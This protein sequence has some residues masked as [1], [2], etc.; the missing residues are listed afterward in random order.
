MSEASFD[1]VLR[2]PRLHDAA[3]KLAGE[4]VLSREPG[5]LM[6]YW[7][8]KAGVQQIRLAK[9]MGL[10]PSV[11]SDYEGGRRKSPGS[12]FIR[13]YVA[14]LV[15]MDRERGVLL[16]S[17][18]ADDNPDAILSIGEFREPISVSG[19][20]EALSLEILTGEDQLDRSLYGYTV[21]DSIRAIYALSGVEFYRIFGS[22]TERILVFTKV[23]MGRS[24]LVAV[25]VSQL[26]PRMVVVHGPERV[27]PLSVELARRE[28]IVMAVARI[29]VRELVGKLSS[30]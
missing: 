21:L 12:Q 18:P 13:K 24:P 10:S 22:T 20:A 16:G 23:G 28:R 19:I 25:R 9:E 4:L 8:E 1:D 2:D 17:K 27:D 14:S 7:R 6:K 15:K 5:R 29:G 3:I 11:L 26:K 30:L